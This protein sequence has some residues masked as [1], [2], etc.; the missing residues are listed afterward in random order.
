MTSVMTETQRLLLWI[1]REFSEIPHSVLYGELFAITA[2]HETNG[3]FALAVYQHFRS[4]YRGRVPALDPAQVDWDA[5]A[6]VI[7]LKAG[8]PPPEQDWEDV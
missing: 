2:E 3:T 8:I 7:G 4:T 6:Q 5:V 1:E